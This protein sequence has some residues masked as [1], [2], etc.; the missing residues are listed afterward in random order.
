[1]LMEFTTL[2]A[3]WKT[4]SEAQTAQVQTQT[5]LAEKGAHCSLIHKSNLYPRS[6]THVSC[7][8]SPHLLK[9]LLSVF[10]VKG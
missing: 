2:N 4:H 5:D 9:T 6:L 10:P 8:T 3:L 1:M 7:L